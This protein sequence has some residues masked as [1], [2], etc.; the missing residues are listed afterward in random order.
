MQGMN[1]TERTV[2]RISLLRGKSAGF[3]LI[4][5]GISLVVRLIPAYLVHGS[6]DVGAWELVI[7]EYR[8]GN[9]PYETGKLNWPPLWPMLLLYTLRLED[10][11]SVPT[12]F[13]VKLI[14]CLADA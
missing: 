4:L 11:Y 9:N 10:V 12:H 5:L 2:S 14:P 8:V 1:Y 13:S 7:R 3:V 6:F